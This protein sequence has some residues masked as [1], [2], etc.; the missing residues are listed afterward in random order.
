MTPEG[1]LRTPGVR[2]APA[3]LWNGAEDPVG[4]G[5]G[6]QLMPSGGGHRGRGTGWQVLAGLCI[7]PLSLQLPLQSAPVQLG[8]ARAEMSL[9]P[10]LN[11]KSK[12]KQLMNNGKNHRDRP[13]FQRGGTSAEQ[14]A[15]GKT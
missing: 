9:H 13:L 8:M 4:K 11:E 3:V 12:V 6:T 5:V 2:E 1:Q 10:P 7:L 15:L 14:S